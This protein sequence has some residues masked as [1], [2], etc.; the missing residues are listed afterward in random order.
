MAAIYGKRNRPRF[1]RR[2]G[3]RRPHRLFL[4]PGANLECPLADR[5]HLRSVAKREELIEQRAGAA[6]WQQAAHL[7][8]GAF[9]LRRT[10]VGHDFRDRGDGPSRGYAASARTEAR[11]TNLHDTKQGP[12]SPAPEIL[13][14]TLCATMITATS[15]PAMLL[16][17]R[18][19]QMTVQPGQGHF[20]FR[21]RQPQ[22]FRRVFDRH[23]PAGADLVHLRGSLNP[24]QFDHDP[25]PHPALPVQC[26]RSILGR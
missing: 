2:S 15:A 20:P 8:E 4:E 5:L 25:P 26:Y 16:C 21:Y 17:L 22:G 24:G 14:R 13:E 7:G 3:G 19:D 9:I 23:R 6:V 1:V 11:G 10:T 18:L 12:Q